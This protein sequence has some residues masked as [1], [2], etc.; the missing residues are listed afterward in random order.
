MSFRDCIQSALSS[1]R[2][3]QK[4]ADEAF[5]AYDEAFTRARATEPEAVADLTAAKSVL[6][7]ITTLKAGKRHERLNIMQRGHEIY[8]R[9]MASK[10][11][12]AELQNIIVDLEMSQETV[13]SFAMANIDRLMDKYGPKAAGFYNNKNFDGV[14][15][16]AYRTGGTP[17]EVA[18]AD[19]ILETWRMLGQWAN[20][21]GANIK[22]NPNAR[23]PQTQEAIRVR[24]VEPKEFIDDHLKHADWEVM[25]FQ[26]KPIPVDKREEIL[27]HTYEGIVSDGFDR[28]ETA[29][30]SAPGLATR[31]NRDR[32]IYYKS[33]ESYR[34]MQEKYGA[35]NLYEQTINMVESLAKDISLLKTFGPAAD[36][37]RE[38]TKRT[39]L[40][41]AADLNLARPA[42]KRTL[43]DYMKKQV[44]LF[45]DEMAIH[46]WH[47]VSADGN[48]PVQ[49]ISAARSIAVGALLG[50]SFIT[51]LW[52][53][54]GNASR[55]KHVLNMPEVSVFRSYTKEF[56][57]GKRAR[58]EAAQAGV[59][60]QG[61][62]SL[63]HSRARYYGALDGPTGARR[64]S[65]IM[66][67]LGLANY[68]TQIMRQAQGQQLMGLWAIHAGD[69]FD[70]LPFAPFLIE[71]GIT[72]K[73]WDAFRVM[74]LTDVRGAK[75]LI[76]R[77]MFLSGDKVTAMKFS[78]AMQLYIRM[79]VPD[80]SLRSRRALG[81]AVDPNSAAGQ[82]VRTVGSLFSFPV[83]I[84]YN[85]LGKMHTMP[86]IRDK[87]AFGAKYFTVMTFAG[88]AII[89]MRA[90]VNH[91]NP[92]DMTDVDTWAKAAQAGGG[93][94]F[95]GDLIFN[96]INM[97]NSA[98]P[99]SNPTMNFLDR[100][101]Q[102]VVG[103]LWDTAFADEPPTSDDV[104]AD[105]LRLVDA[106][107]PDLWYISLLF[108]RSIT[109]DWMQTVDPAGWERRQQYMRDSHE[110]G[111]WWA[112]GEPLQM[113]DFS[114]AIGGGAATDE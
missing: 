12:A 19:S 56:L 42:N 46:S 99:Y 103:N 65:D 39:A 51:S 107:V 94:G 84:W 92:H 8:T 96:S 101:R 6:E 95:I 47:V 77:Q 55:M 26:G 9:L 86:N 1:G 100:A 25:E 108:N 74:P 37:M 38:F 59:I 81:E 71:R 106:S 98:R 76:P 13:R 40:K 66:Y 20:M 90:I 49:A 22:E 105:S 72:K 67:R 44:K 28:P 10:D 57:G 68:H 32:F 33:A 75:F 16:A 23:L 111:S 110:E 109:D 45:D 3:S 4:K 17:D 24:A 58:M 15:D 102:L 41:R 36:S 53:D 80:T 7:E 89:Q 50:K 27:R 11:P 112:P 48:L 29:Q 43:V 91:Q 62:I 2:L 54:L 5:T 61:K 70:D 79:M 52:S 63:I 85:Q 97:S 113:P 21:Y 73:D 30:L 60:M 31:L 87:V 82:I 114:T 34:L 104:A 88:L 83:S 69:E 35:G 18:H 64:V 78:D 93:L 14:I